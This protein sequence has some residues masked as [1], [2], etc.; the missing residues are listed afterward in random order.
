MM[1]SILFALALGVAAVAARAET[2][3]YFF[4]DTEDYTCDESNDAIRDLANILAAEGVCGNFNIVGYLATRLVELKRWD[5][6]NAL[7]NHVVGTQTLYHTRHPDIAEIG[8]DPDYARAYRR[9]L[10]EEA[11]GI[12]M[13]EA[14]F[15][16]GCCVFG[17][18]PGNSVSAVAMDVYSDL[19]LRC[20][21]GTGF[22][23][24]ARSFGCYGDGMLVRR[25]RKVD[26]LWY[27]N[28]YQ[29]P[30]YEGFSLESLLPARTPTCPDFKPI[31][32]AMTGFD[33]AVLYMHPHMAIKR[34]H[35]DGPNY[36]GGN[37]VPWRQW[38]QV[39]SYPPEETAEFYRRLSAF[40][41]AVKADPRLRVTD[42]QE[43][44]VMLRPRKPIVRSD[45]PGLRQAL[46]RDFG[47]VSSPA[48]WC[49]ADVF[50]AA[51]RFL[52]GE[53]EYRP[54]KVYGFLARPKGVAKP[55]VVTAA[56][57]KRTAAQI[58]LATFLPP[59]ISVGETTVGPADFLF[60]AL[61]VLE[62]GADRVTVLPREQLGSFRDI[63]SIEKMNLKG[64][65]L[66]TPEFKDEFL[67]ERLRLQLWTMRFER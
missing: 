11:R 61:E 45:V 7:T 6:V 54:G 36:R 41:K 40:L 44:L 38:K 22:Y 2:E 59:E 50:Q 23:G 56:D 53:A 60:A 26:G 12:G 37:L 51:V 4:F 20:L 62:T 9:T 8:D 29:L 32:D 35:W 39:E 13:V 66:H 55:T 19:G 42:L 10:A 5:V 49:V 34:A 21:C 30:Y 47:P 67:S 58:D 17:C 64:T 33:I 27:A 3:V 16:E 28:M 1:K 48:S 18:F 63:P 15:G 25:G 52:R 14:V 31:L 43:K 24:P 46:L 65:W 57:L